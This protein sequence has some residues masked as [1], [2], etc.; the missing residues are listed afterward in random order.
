MY[1]PYGSNTT[2]PVEIAEL[3]LVQQAIQCRAAGF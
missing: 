3:E 1:S 2:L